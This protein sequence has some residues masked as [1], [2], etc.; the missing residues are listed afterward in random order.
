MT[1]NPGVNALLPSLKL[2]FSPLKIGLPNRNVVFQPSI[3]R[4]YVSFRECTQWLL[5][6][7]PLSSVGSVANRPSPNW[8]E[9]HTTYLYH[10]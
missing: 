8:Q 9:I 6:L 1:P 7:V 5:F 3:F 2:T 4:G 10:L